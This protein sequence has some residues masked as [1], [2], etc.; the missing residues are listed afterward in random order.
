MRLLVH[1]PEG[2]ACNMGWTVRDENGNT[3]YRGPEWAANL[4][5]KCPEVD[6]RTGLARR[7]NSFN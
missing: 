6:I 5:V 3:L 4:R 2:Y 1:D 7:L